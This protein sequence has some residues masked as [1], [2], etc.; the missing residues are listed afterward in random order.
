MRLVIATGIYPPD[1]GGP[2]YYAEGLAAAFKKAGHSVGV[3]QYGFLKRLPTG[4]RHLVYALKLFPAACFADAVIA[5]DTFS[6]AL[7]AALVCSVTRTP[8][9]IRTGGDFLWEAYAERTHHLIPLQRFYQEHRP[10]TLKERAIFRLTKF[11]LRRG[12]LVFST[13]MQRDVWQTP[14]K[15]DASRME[16]IGNAVLEPLESE[17]PREKNYLWHVRPTA[18]KNGE[19]VRAAFAKAKEKHPDIII[20]EGILPKAELLSRMRS[21]YAVILPSVTEVS[22]NYILD[23]LRFRKPFIMDKYSGLAPWLAPY[24]ILVDP[25]DEDDIANALARLAE[26]EG[27]E[28]AKKKA[29]A[30]SFTQTYDD[31]AKDFLGL[32][33]RRHLS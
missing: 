21:C 22:P 3:A 16:V 9:I 29:A 14:Y 23:A 18:I 5:L 27:Y 15:L 17:T 33:E 31:V 20:E 12:T 4:I 24:G 8:L 10:F 32:I 11:I 2:A 30:F 13:A 25:L 19:H 1:V 26:S 6:V 7:P 28:E